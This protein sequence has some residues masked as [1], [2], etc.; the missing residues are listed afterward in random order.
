MRVLLL[1]RGSPASGKSTY[2][3]EHNLKQYSLSADEIRLQLQA[4]VL[5]NEGNEII[6]VEKERE[7]WGLLFQ[8]LEKRMSRGDFTVI[9][10]TNSKTSEMARYKEL[11]DK[12]RYRI[13][14]I[15]KI[16]R[17]SCRERV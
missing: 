1:F 4:P 17:A 11:A 8:M 12:Y 3:Q 10:A 15:D 13:Y 16:G 7:V 5:N 2:I 14:I 6:H 9:D